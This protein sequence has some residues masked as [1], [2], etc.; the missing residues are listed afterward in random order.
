MS[1]Q[2]VLAETPLTPEAAK[3]AL[4]KAIEEKKPLNLWINKYGKVVGATL[5]QPE[6]TEEA[7]FIRL[8][9]EAP[10]IPSFPVCVAVRGRL[11]T[12]EG[13]PMVI[14]DLPK[15]IKAAESERAR[16]YTE[17]EKEFGPSA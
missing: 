7:T 9:E 1:T 14:A 5:Q 8:A 12:N 3:E 17:R 11:L 16:F 15:A 2:L 6:K 10:S 13:D 4:E